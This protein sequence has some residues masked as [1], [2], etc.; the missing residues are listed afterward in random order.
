MIVDDK[1]TL[2]ILCCCTSS[3]RA[4]LASDCEESAMDDVAAEPSTIKVMKHK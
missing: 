3:R 4:P 1:L 2:S